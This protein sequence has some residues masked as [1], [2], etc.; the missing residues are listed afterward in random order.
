M[1][2]KDPPFATADEH[3]FCTLIFYDPHIT[4]IWVVPYCFFTGLLLHTG[5]GQWR[6]RLNDV[7][8]VR[9]IFLHFRDIELLHFCPKAGSNI[10][11]NAKYDIVEKHNF[12]SHRWQ[13]SVLTFCSLPFMGYS[14]ASLMHCLRP[15]DPRRV[16]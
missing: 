14:D 2:L 5:L 13:C 11:E 4:Y 12:E 6:L 9:R 10:L 1:L 15:T 3:S 8:W 7:N 16:T